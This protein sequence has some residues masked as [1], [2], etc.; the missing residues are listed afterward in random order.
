MGESMHNKLTQLSYI[1]TTML[2]LDYIESHLGTKVMRTFYDEVI[3][4]SSDYMDQNALWS[5]RLT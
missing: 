2:L 5:S 3:K 4:S 1:Q